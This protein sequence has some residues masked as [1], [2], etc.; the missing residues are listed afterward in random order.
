MADGLEMEGVTPAGVTLP[1]AAAPDGALRSAMPIV[2]VGHVDHGKSTLVGRLINDTGSMPAGKVEELRAVCARRGMR[3]EW[4]FLMDAFQAERDQGVTIDAAQIWFRGRTRDYVIIDA[5]GHR[6]FL[7]NMVTGAARA[8]A[9]VLVID[10]AEGVREQSR[11]HGYLLHLLGVRQVVVVVNKMDLA[12][13]SSERFATISAEM[14]AYLGRLG[15]MP[16]HVIPVSSRDG[17]NVATRSERMDWY[18]GPTVVDALDGFAPPPLPSDLPLR[19]PLQDV[20]RFD[21]R[22]I[23][24]GRIESGRLRPGDELLF[25]PSNKT[26]RVA[27]IESWPEGGGARA[28]AS[29]GESVGIVLDEQI[30]VERGEI[31]SH[32]D[33]IGRAS[34]R[35]RG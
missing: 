35:E 7:K 33:E 8:E 26:A 25:S 21:E 20:Y 15:V 27:R 18:R 2:M 5:P 4:A 32:V 12:E 1:A 16:M 3:F 17:D 30:F 22:R 24:A 11:R 23:L 9:A 34:C 19:L 29:A 13:F 28:E 14:R 31:A 10:A 6:E